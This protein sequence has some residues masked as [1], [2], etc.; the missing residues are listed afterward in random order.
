LDWL[1]MYSRK[2][3]YGRLYKKVK[4]K[5]LLYKIILVCFMSTIYN[6]NILY[7]IQFLQC[8][9]KVTVILPHSWM[10]IS[11][12]IC[13]IKCPSPTS[14]QENGCPATQKQH[15]KIGDQDFFFHDWNNYPYLKVKS[16]VIIW[17]IVEACQHCV[18]IPR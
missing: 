14:L 9:W 16:V 15:S 8:L 18:F 7:Q 12:W 5:K 1:P 3:V 13:S 2:F 11:L 17:K 10:K 4:K 6:H